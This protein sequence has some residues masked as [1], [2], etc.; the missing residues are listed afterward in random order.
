MP[1][2][3]GRSVPPAVAVM[4]LGLGCGAFRWDEPGKV[5]VRGRVPRIEEADE[6]A[7]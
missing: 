4:P 6:G 1:V 2:Q 5:V 3:A 7:K